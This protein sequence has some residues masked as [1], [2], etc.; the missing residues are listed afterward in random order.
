MKILIS[1]NFKK[2]FNTYID[3]IDHN[4]IKY[5]DK[6]NHLFYLIPNSIK[7]TNNLINNIDK[8]DLIILTGGN[9]LFGGDR[10][11]VS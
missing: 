1:S 7:N 10:I 3:F 8:I 4:W 6:K 9:D 5:F 2:H 11:P